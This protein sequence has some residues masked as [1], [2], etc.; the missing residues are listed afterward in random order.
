[1]KIKLLLLPIFL[2]IGIAVHAT[3]ITIN[4]TGMIFSPATATLNLGDT[5]KFVYIDGSDHTTTST[6]VPS[7]AAT[8]DAPLTPTNTTFIYVPTKAGDYA[9]VCTP[10]APGMA[11]TFKVNAPASISDLNA[12]NEVFEIY[13]NPASSVL[14]FTIKE[15]AKPVSITITDMLGRPAVATQPQKPEKLDLISAI[16]QMVFTSPV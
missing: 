5:V 16:Y 2:L 3:T 15:S 9:Y 13:P 8:W 6:S 7:G 1:M 4:A 14:N 10:H 12:V 11:G